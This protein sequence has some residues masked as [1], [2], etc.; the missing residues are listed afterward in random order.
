MC[1]AGEEPVADRALLV[2]GGCWLL[3]TSHIQADNH[4]HSACI[5]WT[6]NLRNVLH[7]WRESQRY[8]HI[9]VHT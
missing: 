5:M 1:D 2:S 3:L 9:H 7:L 8:P 4:S 6:V